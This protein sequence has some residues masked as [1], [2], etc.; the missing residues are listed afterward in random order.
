MVKWGRGGQKAAKRAYVASGG[1]DWILQA[2]SKKKSGQKR[3]IF[4]QIVWALL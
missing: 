3:L 1:K 4:D 2:V